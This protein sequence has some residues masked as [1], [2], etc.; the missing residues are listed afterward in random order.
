MLKNCHS[1]LARLSLTIFLIVTVLSTQSAEIIPPTATWRYLP[2]RTEASSPDGTA[3]RAPGF[4]DSAWASGPAPF[5]FGEPFTGTELKE[6]L[7][8]YSSLYLRQE[9]TVD[10]PNTVG[11]MV[12]RVLADDGFV[13]WLNGKEIGRQNVPDG[14]FLSTALASTAL[15][16]PLAAE[17]ITV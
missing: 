9:F 7:N 5:F 1:L 15:P 16:E 10:D 17:E 6:M 8:S 3:W 13:A 12:V 2:G 11:E 4:N 14:E